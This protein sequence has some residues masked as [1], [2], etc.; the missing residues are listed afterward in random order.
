MVRRL[1]SGIRD[2]QKSRKMQPDQS[3]RVMIATEKMWRLRAVMEDDNHFRGFLRGLSRPV[4][5]CLISSAAFLVG[6]EIAYSRAL[7]YSSQPRASAHASIL[8]LL[9]LPWAYSLRGLWLLHSLAK[10]HDLQGEINRLM[11]YLALSPVWAYSLLA[12]AGICP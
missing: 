11:L 4:V 7:L 1:R 8:F 3:E 5:M 12:S 9:I 2:N 10:R 6:Y